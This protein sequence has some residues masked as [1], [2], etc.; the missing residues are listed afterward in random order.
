VA[1][2]VYALEYFEVYVLDN[3]VTVFTD[4]KAPVQSYLPYLKSQTKGILARWYL[5]L[6]RFLKVEYKL[7]SANVVADALSKTP[8]VD[9]S[10]TSEVLLVSS[11]SVPVGGEPDMPNNLQFVQEQQREDS[12]LVRLMRFLETKKLRGSFRS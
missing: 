4:H 10:E 1:A 9:S 11:E 7:G 2:L 8:I 12:E 5:R 3:Q 6:A